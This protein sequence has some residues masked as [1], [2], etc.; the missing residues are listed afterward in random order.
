MA[1]PTPNM[2]PKSECPHTMAQSNTQQIQY[3]MQDTK[4]DLIR[5]VNLIMHEYQKLCMIKLI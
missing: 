1:E 5:V 4:Q 3:Y 2:I